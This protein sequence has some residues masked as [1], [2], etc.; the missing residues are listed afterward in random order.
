MTPTIA[1][2]P[3]RSAHAPTGGFRFVRNLR[4]IVRLALNLS[5]SWLDRLGSPRVVADRIALATEDGQTMTVEVSGAGRPLLL[6]HGLGGSHHDWD[7]VV[8]SL[9]RT[10]RVYTLDLR[11]H[12][13]RAGRGAR[14][15]LERMARDVS[16][17]IEGLA[18][19]RPVL[20]GHSMG[21]LVVMQYLKHYGADKLAGVCLVDQSPRITVDTGWGLGLFGT[22]TAGQLQA[23]L[24]RL[25]RLLRFA[26]LLSML[27]SLANADFRDVIAALPLPALIVL[28]GASHHYGG[29]PLAGYYRNTLARACIATYDAS[30]HSPHREEPQRFAADLAAFVERHCA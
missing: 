1:L 4:G 21:A 15:T 27:E 19:D 16:Q 2:Q 22:L 10:H 20:A 26:P 25:R 7:G 6:L 30:A 11:G 13:A 24:A 23:S 18:L 17:V 12:G 8:E 5:G 29:L 9:A 3:L 14:P 28:G